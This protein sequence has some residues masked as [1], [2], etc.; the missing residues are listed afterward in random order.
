MVHKFSFHNNLV[1]CAIV[2][3]IKYRITDKKSDE[4]NSNH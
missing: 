4:T 2:D 3:P 1:L